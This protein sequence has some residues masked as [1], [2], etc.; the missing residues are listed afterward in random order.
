MESEVK[1]RGRSHLRVRVTKKYKKGRV[2]ITKRQLLELRGQELTCNCRQFLKR[3]P[4][5]FLGKEDRKKKVLYVDHLAIALD[6]D[7]NGKKMLRMHR[8]RKHRCPRKIA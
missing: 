3:K 8:K 7:E 1:K 6:W 5:I 4:Y 2:K